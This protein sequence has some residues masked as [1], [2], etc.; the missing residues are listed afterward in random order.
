MDCRGEVSRWA[1]GW[2]RLRKELPGYLFIAPAMLLILVF[3]FYP[4]LRSVHLSFTRF[5]P[6]ESSW[7]GL[8][9]YRYLISDDLLWRALRVT[10]GTRGKR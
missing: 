5:S 7:V 3:A 4:I 2:K 9:N 6:R 8:A 10:H 1:V